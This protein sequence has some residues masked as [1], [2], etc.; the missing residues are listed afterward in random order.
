MYLGVYVIYLMTRINWVNST[1]EMIKVSFLDIQQTSWYTE[2]TTRELGQQEMQL[3]FY[4]MI[5]ADQY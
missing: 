4:L 3:M 1:L 5:R 2:S